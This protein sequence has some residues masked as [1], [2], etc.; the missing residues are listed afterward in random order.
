MKDEIPPLLAQLGA[1]CEELAR[2]LQLLCQAAYEL[3]TVLGRI[4]PPTPHNPATKLLVWLLEETDY[5]TPATRRAAH[6]LCWML[7]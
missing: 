5:L 4:A 6:A 2:G 1:T 3:N 7:A